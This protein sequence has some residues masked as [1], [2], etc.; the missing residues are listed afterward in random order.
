MGKENKS[1]NAEFAKRVSIVMEMLL[2][3]LRRCEILEFVRKKDGLNWNVVNSQID[4]YIKFANVE[5]K[6]IAEKDTEKNYL[7]AK[8]RYEFLYRKLINVKDYKG[9]MSIVEREILLDGLITQQKNITLTT[10]KKMSVEDVVS[11]MEE[12][13]KKLEQNK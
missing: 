6:K 5:I 11:I 8:S 9:A 10:E 2:S 12:A 1:N 4:N 3:G 7:K 13:E